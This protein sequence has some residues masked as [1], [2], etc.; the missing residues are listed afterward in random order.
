M[1]EAVEEDLDEM[2]TRGETESELEKRGHKKGEGTM[3]VEGG[4]RKEKA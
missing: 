2:R 4:N 3:V 1:I